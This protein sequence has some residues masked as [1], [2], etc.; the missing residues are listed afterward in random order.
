M[1]ANNMRSDE[2][3]R[4]DY[5][6]VSVDEVGGDVD[7]SYCTDYT[8]PDYPTISDYLTYP[9]RCEQWCLTHYWIET[10]IN[11]SCQGC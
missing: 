2:P 6:T 4:S 11:F 1:T 5:G 9:Y 7:N 3:K 8:L 10:V